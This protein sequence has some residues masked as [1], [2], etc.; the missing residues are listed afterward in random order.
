M[1]SKKKEVALNSE[2]QEAVDQASAKIAELKQDASEAVTHAFLDAVKGHV[3]FAVESV[4]QKR[5]ALVSLNSLMAQIHYAKKF[6][7]HGAKLRQDVSF[8]EA[9]SW[10]TNHVRDGGGKEWRRVIPHKRTRELHKL[11][12]CRWYWFKDAKDAVLFKL[13]WG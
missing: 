12:V 8:D 5:A 13:T 4:S 3:V 10:C 2:L 6:T 11:D 1:P 9:D 7:P